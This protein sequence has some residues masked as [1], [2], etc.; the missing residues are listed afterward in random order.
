MSNALILHSPA[1]VTAVPQLTDRELLEQLGIHVP[2]PTADRSI[3]EQLRTAFPFTVDK[4]RLSGP[5][6]MRTQWYGLF[7]SDTLQPIGGGSVSARYTPHTLDQVVEVVEA[8]REVFDGPV[9]LSCKF[10]DG[11]HVI[12][13]PTNTQSHPIFGNADHIMPSMILLGGYGGTAFQATLGVYRTCCT[14]LFKLESV[15]ASAVSIR[16]TQGVGH[17]IDR[18]VDTFRR[19]KDSWEDITSIAQQ[20]EAQPIALNEYLKMVF[21]ED[22]KSPRQRAVEGEIFQR[23]LSERRA[24]GRPALGSSRIVSV[25]EAFNAVQGYCQHGKTR[26]GENGGALD[27]ALTAL[28]DSTV[29]QA[30]R[31][32]LSLLA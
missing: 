12:L 27:R 23:L 4:Y 7:R 9:K 16:H 30:E 20:M 32:A 17:K 22:E 3:S 2:P 10:R 11:H 31:V 14:N 26:K 13:R 6:N 29:S 15:R 24:T 5:D 1:P 28:D 18:L 21:D 8:A 25:W 19:L